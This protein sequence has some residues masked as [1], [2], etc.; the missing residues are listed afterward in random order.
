MDGVGVGVGDGDT[1]ADET[2]DNAEDDTFE[3]GVGV[4]VGVGVGLGVGDT[5]AE[6][7]LEAAEE[8]STV[9]WWCGTPSLSQISMG[10]TTSARETNTM[11]QNTGQNGRQLRFSTTT[12]FR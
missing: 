1:D 4:G 12:V 5:H 10:T 2:F 8:S 11:Q 6:E 7:E 3:T 9:K